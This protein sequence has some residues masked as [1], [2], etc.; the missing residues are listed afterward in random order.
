MVED[1]IRKSDKISEFGGEISWSKAHNGNLSKINRLA[2]HPSNSIN[3]TSTEVQVKSP[4]RLD[5]K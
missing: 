3:K 1:V 2:S 5:G 4:S